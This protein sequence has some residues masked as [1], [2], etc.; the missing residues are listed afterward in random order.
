MKKQEIFSPVISPVTGT[1]VL[2]LEYETPNVCYRIHV[3]VMIAVVVYFIRWTWILYIYQTFAKI[4][5]PP[6]K[7]RVIFQTLSR[8][9]NLFLNHSPHIGWYPEEIWCE[10]IHW[11]AFYE[12]ISNISNMKVLYITPHL[13]RFLI[14]AYCIK[15]NQKHA[16]IDA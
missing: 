13:R 6:P 15:I 1:L 4:R 16:K 10:N 14:N 7:K 5:G 12:H 8:T 9:S 2:R 3:C 11:L